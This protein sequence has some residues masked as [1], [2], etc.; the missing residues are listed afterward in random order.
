[1]GVTLMRFASNLGR[2]T[3]FDLILRSAASLRR[4][5]KDGSESVPAAILR[6]GRPS[7]S[8]VADFDYFRLPKPG[9][10]DFGGRPPQTQ[11]EVR[12]VSRPLSRAM[13]R[14]L[15]QLS[16]DVSCAKQDTPSAALCNRGKERRNNWGDQNRRSRRGV[17]P[18]MRCPRFHSGFGPDIVNAGS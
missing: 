8:A 15:K 18:A 13:T 9:K 5:S 11:D 2:E 12:I 3:S 1:M 16:P 7:K 4:V 6:D 14:Q 17:V 10:P